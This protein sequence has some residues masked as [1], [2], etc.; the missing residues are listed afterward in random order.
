M[1]IISIELDY[2]N[3]MKIRFYKRLTITQNNKDKYYTN[4]NPDSYDQITIA[5]MLTYY[6][7]K[8]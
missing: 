5:T 7:K 8:R 3:T 4:A 6:M 2:V 1:N